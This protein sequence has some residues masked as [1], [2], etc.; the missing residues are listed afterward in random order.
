MSKGVGYLK[1]SE[2]IQYRLGL[3]DNRIYPNIKYRVKQIAFMKSLDHLLMAEGAP[4]MKAGQYSLLVYCDVVRPQI[5]GNSLV[6]ILRAV[7]I[8]GKSGEVIDELYDNPH[9]V[10][11]LKRE[12]EFI[13]ININDDRGRLTNFQY[14]KLFVKLY[15]RPKA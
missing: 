14:G 15:F 2:N 3:G 4:D 1:F 8:R 10:P 5:V 9:N 13:E 7:S 12:F 11:V 6:P